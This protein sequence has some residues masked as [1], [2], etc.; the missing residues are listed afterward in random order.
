[1]TSGHGRSFITAMGDLI[2]LVVEAHT[3]D[4]DER[5]RRT[6]EVKA[7]KEPGGLRAEIHRLVGHVHPLARLQTFSDDGATFTDH[8]K[9]IAVYRLPTHASGGGPPKD[10]DRL[11]AA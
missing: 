4:T 1:M 10:Q 2:R 6:F 3:V 7:P 5:S 8:R 9:R 11:F